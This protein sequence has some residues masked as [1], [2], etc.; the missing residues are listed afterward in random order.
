MTAIQ[1]P[2]ISV[3]AVE[4]KAG[5]TKTASAVLPL[6]LGEM[7]EAVV[8]EKD[9]DNRYLLTIKNRLLSAFSNIPLSRG[10]KLAV[11]VDQLHPQV[12]LS[13]VQPED[14]SSAIINRYISYS[15]AN[16]DAM[17]EIFLQ[18][19]ELF[20][21]GDMLPSLPKAVRDAGGK[22]AV[23]L[24]ALIFS[25][26]SEKGPVQTP[27]KG[28]LADI[29]VTLESALRQAL[30]GKSDVKDVRQDSLK[31]LLQKFGDLLKIEQEKENSPETV[32]NLA[33][34]VDFSEKAVKTIEG[35]QIIN[36]QSGGRE[37]NVFLQ[38][39]VAL[40]NDVR[41]AD[42]FINAEEDGG[43][44]GEGRRYNVSMFLDLD[45]LGEMMAEAS[46]FGNKLRCML[47]FSDPATAEFVSVFTGDLEKNIREI[48]F[49]DVSLSCVH[50]DAIG[51]AKNVCYRE[52]FSDREMVNVFA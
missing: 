15:R 11:R 9:G 13:I 34:L 24:N 48:G 32:K 19:L 51:R 31:A 18:G 41:V 47:K 4:K 39:P 1:M 14:S 28:Y 37:G 2:T 27:L 43:G 25:N 17:K 20:N 49:G 7:A 10:E 50:S 5:E 12:M 40:P 23:L 3:S 22:I 26:K 21:D 29:G 6:A 35:Q 44:A 16:P 30:E 46:L 36:A 33:K 52:L 45:A 8:N 42:L 38:V